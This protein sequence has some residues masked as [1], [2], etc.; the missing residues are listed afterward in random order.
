MAKFTRADIRK[1]L[2]EAHTEE[3]ENQIMALHL[4]VVDAIKDELSKA[5]A[6]ADKLPGVQAELDKLKSGKE[7]DDSYKT[8]YEKEHAEFEKF[9]TDQAE[10]DAKA[11]KMAKYRALL[12][13]AGVS[14]KRLDSVLKVTDMD[15]VKLDKDGNIEDSEKLL[16]TIKT[17]WADFIVKEGAKG[18]D[19]GN[20]PA[21][22][23]TKLSKDEIYKTD[24]K[25]RFI[26]DAQARQAALAE[27]AASEE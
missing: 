6:D 12:K 7:D 24:E 21:S 16:G 19:T 15:S 23:G 1:I 20:P 10:K 14:E 27:L 11:D 4:G 9:K 5:K 3:I 18:A 25:G 8:K 26:L 22:T 17:E 2:G 13:K